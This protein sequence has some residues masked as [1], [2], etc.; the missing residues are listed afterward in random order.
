MCSGHSPCPARLAR[1]Q[2]ASSPERKPKPSEQL[3]ASVLSQNNPRESD[4]ILRRSRDA[5]AC[6]GKLSQCDRNACGTPCG[7]VARSVIV[8]CDQKLS[9]RCRILDTIGVGQYGP[10]G[11][12]RAKS[13]EFP[14]LRGYGRCP[15]TRAARVIGA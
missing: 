8:A 1:K 3:N 13:S 11:F 14:L 10:R 5:W 6:T 2:P 12:A 4:R 9:G 7:T 15:T